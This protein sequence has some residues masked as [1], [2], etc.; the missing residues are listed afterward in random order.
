MS[1]LLDSMIET[2]E[3]SIFFVRPSDDSPEVQLVCS[4]CKMVLLST[5]E[6][7]LNEL[8]ERVEEHLNGQ[9]S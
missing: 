2:G 4:D 3:S 5:V 7:D 6:L 1:E 8:L 9:R